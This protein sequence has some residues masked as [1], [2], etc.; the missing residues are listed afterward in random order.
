MSSLM[1]S[2]YIDSVLNLYVHAYGNSITHELWRSIHVH[3]LGFAF[4]YSGTREC[5]STVCE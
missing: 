4:S 1:F 3:V 2:I 5:V